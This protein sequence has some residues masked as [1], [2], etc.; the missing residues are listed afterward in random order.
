MTRRQTGSRWFKLFTVFLLVI[1]GVSCFGHSTPDEEGIRHFGKV[2]ELIYRGPTP[3]EK[4]FQTLQRFGV[5]TIVDLRMVSRKTARAEAAAALAH[6]MQYTNFPMPGVGRPRPKQVRRTLDY[7]YSSTNPVYLFCRRGCDR[8]GLVIACYRIEHDHWS[9]ESAL[10]EAGRYGLSMFER[11]MKLC[12]RSF[13]YKGLVAPA[14]ARDHDPP[15]LI[16]AAEQQ[17]E[18]LMQEMAVPGRQED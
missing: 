2:D 12:I 11:G 6:G 1:S 3:T 15:C 8:T 10:Q 7:I 5:K 14:N 4:T 17:R 18:A 13:G 9:Q 16:K